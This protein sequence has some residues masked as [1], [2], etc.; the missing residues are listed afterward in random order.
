MTYSFIYK[1]SFLDLTKI[2][3]QELQTN[4]EV[5]IHSKWSFP[6]G[7]YSFHSG[8][9]EY[10]AI[11]TKE[12]AFHNVFI[13]FQPDGKEIVRMKN[14]SL[15]KKKSI[16]KELQMICNHNSYPIKST[17]AYQTITIRNGETD[18]L[19]ANKISPMYKSLLNMYD[20]EV[21]VQHTLNLPCIVWV[22]IFKGIHLLLR[23]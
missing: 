3:I 14:I 11:S 23:H 6:M 5:W 2:R 18:I 17:F 19:T 16:F 13:V 4:E 8:K 22:A 9:E 10:K 1:D 20:Y 12:D 21:H 7:K 15:H